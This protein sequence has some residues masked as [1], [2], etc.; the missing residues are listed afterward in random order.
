MWVGLEVFNSDVG[1]A[2]FVII[3]KCGWAIVVN[4]GGTVDIIK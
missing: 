4:V 1:R 3:H 2:G